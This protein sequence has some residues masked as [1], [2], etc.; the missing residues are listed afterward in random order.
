MDNEYNSKKVEAML[1]W[2][3]S[4]DEEAIGSTVVNP[5]LSCSLAVKQISKMVTK[6]DDE[7]AS[8]DFN[9]SQIIK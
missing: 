4:E 8:D 1:E 5:L 6:L 9:N 7:T 2:L 3:F